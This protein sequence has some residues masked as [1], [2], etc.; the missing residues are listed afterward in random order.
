[1]VFSSATFLFAFLPLT[2]ILYALIPNLKWRNGLLIFMSLLFYAWGEGL[3]VLLMLGSVLFNWVAGLLIAD[4]KKIARSVTAVAVIFNIGLLFAFKYVG[5]FTEGLN[6]LPGVGLTVPVIHLPIGISFF[7]FQALSYVVDVKRN[8]ETVQ[9]N[10]F[11]MLLYI[12]FFPQLIAGP[13]VKYHDISEQLQHREFTLD[14]VAN[15]LRRFSFGLAKKLLLADGMAVAVDSIFAKDPASLSGFAAWG[16]AVFYIFQIYFDFS[17]Y[18]DMAIGLGK[19]FGFD[20]LENFRYPYASL[21]VTDFWRRWHISLSTC[22]KEYLYIP[23]GGNRKGAARTYF[24]L[25]IVFLATGIWHGANLTFLVWGIWNG[26]F[27]VL[28]RCGVLKIKWNPLNRLY[29]FLVYTLGFAI[30]RA[31]NVSYAVRYIGRMF[32]PAAYYGGWSDLLGY[33]TPYFLFILAVAVLASAP[34]KPYLENKLQTGSAG[35][36]RSA[37]VLSFVLSFGLLLLCV[38]MIASNTYSPFIYFRF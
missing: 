4:K 10:F 27:I 25:F 9:R 31:D 2:F 5:F 24:N 38:G 29:T 34:I 37:R 20:F 19:M 13:I 11:S 7:T 23:L 15:G 14:R 8:P 36:C 22:F 16:G 17:G 18:S 26:L 35:L 28:E 3:Y 12:S 21:G 6:L 33:L 1:M 30:F 32:T